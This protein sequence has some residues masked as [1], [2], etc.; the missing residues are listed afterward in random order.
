MNLTSTHENKDSLSGLRILCC[1][2]LWC[3]SQIHLRSRVA[4]SA[5]LIQTLAWELPDAAGAALN[6]Q[7]T[8]KTKASIKTISETA[9]RTE[10]RL[11]NRRQFFKFIF[12]AAGI[13]H[14]SLWMLIRVS[15]W[16]S[17]KRNSLYPLLSHRKSCPSSGPRPVPPS[18]F[19]LNPSPLP[20]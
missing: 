2:E 7:K 5:A 20:S 9:V 11:S 3:R 13:K 1:R 4:V 19:A 16:L 10:Y 18:D 14:T 15:V 8:K 17:H 6:R 12:R